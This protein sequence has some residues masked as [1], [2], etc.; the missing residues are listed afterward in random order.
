DRAV[1]GEVQ[2]VLGLRRV[3]PAGHEPELERGLLAALHEVP[4]VEREPEFAVLEDEVLAGVVV[5]AAGR[6]H[7]GETA[8]PECS[9]WGRRHPMADPSFR[10]AGEREFAAR[11]TLG[12]CAP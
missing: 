7:D 5:A 4:L 8:P 12:G 6:I 3:E 2:G 10:T 11:P 1:R 9:V